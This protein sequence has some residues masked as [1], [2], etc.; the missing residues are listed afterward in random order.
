MSDDVGIAI[1]V[2]EGCG[3]LQKCGTGG[4]GYVSCCP[5]SS[6]CATDT[7][8]NVYVRANPFPPSPL[9]LFRGTRMSQDLGR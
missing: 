9:P 2:E 8:G 7:D 4:S 3:L 6:E 1:R 5:D